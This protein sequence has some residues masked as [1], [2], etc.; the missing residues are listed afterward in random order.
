MLAWPKVRGDCGEESTSKMFNFDL[1]TGSLAFWNLNWSTEVTKDGGAERTV[2]VI[3]PRD[4]GISSRSG[5]VILNV[6]P[7][8]APS[9]IVVV[10]VAP[11]HLSVSAAAA[12]HSPQ[13][14]QLDG[15]LVARF[16]AQ[17]N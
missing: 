9:G 14:L 8:T 16:A 5:K 15:Y 4:P 6:S 13:T 7:G 3:P 10:K 1:V 17:W 11:V 2:N 12:V